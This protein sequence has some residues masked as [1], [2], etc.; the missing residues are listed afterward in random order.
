M[1][2]KA[3]ISS[4]MASWTDIW[5]YPDPDVIRFHSFIATDQGKILRS[6][7]D[8]ATWIARHTMLNQNLRR[9][10]GTAAAH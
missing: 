6:D 7:D 9:V 4:D 3:D 1:Q 5:G 8:G 2:Y 10:W